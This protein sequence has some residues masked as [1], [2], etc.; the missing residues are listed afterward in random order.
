M[1]FSSSM[2]ASYVIPVR[3]TSALP[4]A[5]FRFR[6]AADTLAVRLTIP[7]DGLVRDLHPQVSAPCRAHHKKWETS[8][9]MTPIS[10]EDFFCGKSRNTA[11]LFLRNSYSVVFMFFTRLEMNTASAVCRFAIRHMRGGGNDPNLRLISQHDIVY[12]PFRTRGFLTLF[13]TKNFNLIF[14][15]STKYS[16]FSL[17]SGSPLLAKKKTG[18]AMSRSFCV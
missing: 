17:L 7:P 14:N 15:L 6:L 1:A 8:L 4:A 16:S 3:Q 11:I 18:S 12:Y 5:S 2:H 10:W 13:Q 9:V